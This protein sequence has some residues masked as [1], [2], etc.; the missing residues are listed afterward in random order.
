MDDNKENRKAK[1]KEFLCTYDTGHNLSFNNVK[2]R[3][4]AKRT[5]GF[6]IDITTTQYTP[7]RLHLAIDSARSNSTGYK[8]FAPFEIEKT[9]YMEDYGSFG[10]L[11]FLHT[12]Y[13]FHIRIAHMAPK[14]FTE[15]NLERVRSGDSFKAG[16]FIG[17][18]GNAG[19]SFGRHA[20][21]E[22]VSDRNEFTILDDILEEKFRDKNL[23]KSYTDSQVQDY[24]DSSSVDNEEGWELY[25]KE[26]DKRGVNIVNQYLCYRWDYHYQAM[27]T[28]YNSMALFGM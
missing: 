28:F 27:R 14:D 4:G 25:E 18:C 16:E 1:L 20:H 8:I 10:T 6:G 11:L 9:E 26:K 12:S 3:P 7:L 5:T 13:D 19:L 24:I 15:K 21:V 23:Y 2:F 17:E 22:V